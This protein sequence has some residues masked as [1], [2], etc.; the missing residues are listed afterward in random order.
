[1]R[2]ARMASQPNK[3][4]GKAIHQPLTTKRHESLLMA[5]GKATLNSVLPA[6][7]ITIPTTMAEFCQRL[8][9]RPVKPVAINITKLS[10]LYQLHPMGFGPQNVLLIAYA[11][12]PPTVP[13]CTASRRA[14]WASVGAVLATTADSKESTTVAG[15]AFAVT[16]AAVAVWIRVSPPP[17]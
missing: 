1:M 5:R 3:S 6:I 16:V 11:C 9:S 7:T 4:T 14:T 13:F 15:A 8:R 10:S 17:G 12:K 2:Q